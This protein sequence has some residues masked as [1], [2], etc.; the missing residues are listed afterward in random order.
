MNVECF[1]L[2]IITPLRIV[3]RKVHSLR[4]KDRTGFFGI[5]RGH[6]DFLTVLVPALGYFT[7]ADGAEHFLAVDGGIFSMQSGVATL[8]AGDAF[9]GD[10]ASRMAETIDTALT[11]RDSAEQTIS[12][13][14]EGIEQSFLKKIAVLSKGGRR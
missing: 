11:A 4:L 10:D 13:M 5:R 12:Q 14:V 6:C 7:D 8:T 2:E 1:Q 9:E 3:T